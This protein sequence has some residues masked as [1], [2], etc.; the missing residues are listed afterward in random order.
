MWNNRKEAGIELSE[1][2]KNYKAQK[3]VI[4][5][6]L[7]RGGVVVAHEVSRILN[8]PLDVIVTKK[9]GAPDNPELAIGAI[10]ENGM[11]V[12][13]EALIQ[14]SAI[15]REYILEEI[16]KKKEEIKDR[17]NKYRNGRKPLLLKDKRVVLIDDGI[18][19]G[20]TMISAVRSCIEKDAK[21][22]IV[23]TP[24]I[25]YDVVDQIKNIADE[26]IYLKAPVDFQAVGEFYEDFDQVSDD[27]VIQLLNANHLL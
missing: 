4:V 2:L 6:G 25:A 3:D 9:I 13:N 16:E 1:K 26:F 10:D 11:G 15:T 27:E 14:Y 19:T 7:P 17:L 24:V 8:L 20:A 12:F 23:S 18:A 22:I 21:K 5:L